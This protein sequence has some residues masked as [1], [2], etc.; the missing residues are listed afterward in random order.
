MESYS[1][2]WRCFS[3]QIQSIVPI[4]VRS[5]RTWHDGTETNPIIRRALISS[6]R[7]FSV[8]KRSLRIIVQHNLYHC[9][10]DMKFPYPWSFHILTGKKIALIMKTSI[11]CQGQFP[12]DMI[13]HRDPEI[14]V[15]SCRLLL[16]IGLLSSSLH[17]ISHYFF[18]LFSYL[19][20]NLI[21]FLEWWHWIFSRLVIENL[22]SDFDVFNIFLTK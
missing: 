8:R 13:R 9:H 10:H 18:C 15:N 22:L 4:K 11:T 16:F 20:F 14:S 2:R 5:S 7:Y 3:R 1:K 21:H 6:I 19:S 17:P 12:S